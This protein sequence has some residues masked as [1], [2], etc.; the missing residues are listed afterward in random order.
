[1]VLVAAAAAVFVVLGWLAAIQ[2]RKPHRD[3]VLVPPPQR[4]GDSLPPTVRGLPKDDAGEVLPPDREKNKDESIVARTRKI[5]DLV[6]VFAIP[7]ALVVL[8]A[9]TLI[10]GGTQLE[11]IAAARHTATEA[12]K[13]AGSPE[14]P[15]AP[16]AAEAVP[17]EKPQTEKTW[18][19]IGRVLELGEPVAEAAVWAV[20][21]DDLGNAYSP[22]GQKTNALGEFRIDAIPERLTSEPSAAPI[23]ELRISASKSAWLGTKKGAVVLSLM[24]D[25]NILRLSQFNGSWWLSVPILC[26]LATIAVIAFVPENSW[27]A[28]LFITRLIAVLFSGRRAKYYLA[29][30]FTLVLTG[31]MVWVIG[32]SILRFHTTVPSGD[33]R[34]LGF[35]TF[36]EGTY[37]KDAAPEWLISLTSPPPRS[38]DSGKP[39]TAGATNNLAE[40]FGAP[41]WVVFLSV[42]GSALLTVVLVIR[43]ISHPPNFGPAGES[44][45]ASASPNGKSEKAE[46]TSAGPD[47]ASAVP[48]NSPDHPDQT[49]GKSAETGEKAPQIPDKPAETSSAPGE[50]AGE[51]AAISDMAPGTPGQP[52]EPSDVP[53]E[54]SRSAEATVDKAELWKW[55]RAILEHQF[56]ILFAPLSGIFL[57]QLLLV[58]G[59]ATKPIIVAVVI[60]GAGATLNGLLSWAVRLAES[61]VERMAGERAADT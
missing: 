42:V 23:K 30:V 12:P 58:G 54:A 19:I 34:T 22:P 45:T 10:A 8:I 56:F 35:V 15:S 57:Y 36:F 46:Q 33:V 40:G 60:L 29:L 37:V 44:K 3:V 55:R 47:G 11:V 24:Q 2:A 38:A 41:F 39:A 20:A 26:F 43:G 59:A 9:W 5:S 18:T 32:D 25:T 31:S 14:N 50:A 21:Y 28:K 16:A 1:M 48:G 4:D 49:S 52:A 17:T 51:P 27:Q 7:V 61:W 53:A 13:Q 6:V